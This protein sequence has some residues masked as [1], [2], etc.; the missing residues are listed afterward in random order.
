M[1]WELGKCGGPGVVGGE[2]KR[3]CSR[4]SYVPNG[5]NPS[6]EHEGRHAPVCA[7]EPA[8]YQ[9]LMENI[10]DIPDR[11]SSRSSPGDFM[12][13]GSGWFRSGLRKRTSG[14]TSSWFGRCWQFSRRG[15][16]FAHFD[17][18]ASSFAFRW[19]RPNKRLLQLTTILLY[20]PIIE[21]SFSYLECN[22]Q[23]SKWLSRLYIVIRNPHFGLILDSGY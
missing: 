15:C 3:I 5:V 8:P 23:I 22:I 21:I 6:I 1:S 2:R 11:C 16:F 17:R 20:V 14:L 18:H 13:H 7:D 12:Q 19:H 4:R 9:R 10:T